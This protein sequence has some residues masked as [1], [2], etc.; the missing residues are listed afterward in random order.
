MNSF[1]NFK[2]FIHIP[3]SQTYD[4]INLLGLWRRRNVFRVRYEQTY[5]VELSFK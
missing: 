3:L 2:S 5:R 1:Q 4:I